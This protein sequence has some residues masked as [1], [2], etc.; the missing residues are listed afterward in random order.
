MDAP[1]GGQLHIE[2]LPDQVAG[3]GTL[4]TAS[5]D[6]DGICKIM[7]PVEPRSSELQFYKRFSNDISETAAKLRPFFPRYFGVMLID[8]ESHIVM[9]NLIAGMNKP[10]IM[11]IKLGYRQYTAKMKESKIKSCINKA[12][13]S[14]S[15][16]HGMR[17]CGMKLW[18]VETQ[19]F[20]Q[21]QK[22][23]ILADGFEQVSSNICRF[24]RNSKE[25]AEKFDE[26]VAALL[27][28]FKHQTEFRFYSSSLLL[29]YDGEDPSKHDARYSRLTVTFCCPFMVLYCFSSC[30]LLWYLPHS[31]CPLKVLFSM[32]GSFED[33]IICNI[34]IWG[35]LT[36]SAE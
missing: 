33:I 29:V 8:M 27:D 10:C 28:I 22:T 18:N 30:V 7:K 25:L 20:E 31:F 12:T 3:H 2:L 11:D 24:V 36:F 32:S 6:G 23:E 26:P 4:L 17:I 5:D 34:G 13:I 35:S 16:S 14:T 15:G 19:E 1:P 21:K 9:E